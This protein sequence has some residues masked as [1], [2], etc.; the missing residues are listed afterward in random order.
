M[1]DAKNRNLL[2]CVVDQ[3]EHSIL[4]LI[5]PESFPPEPPGVP[6]SLDLLAIVRAGISSKTQHAHDNLARDFGLEPLEV[7]KDA[8]IKLQRV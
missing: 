6:K 8:S 2:V 4:P 5:Q 1:G 7:P 3:V